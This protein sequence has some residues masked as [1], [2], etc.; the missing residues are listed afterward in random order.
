MA[1]CHEI[2]RG[3]CLHSSSALRSFLGLLS[4]LH[5]SGTWWNIFALR[6]PY[7][8]TTTT[9][10]TFEQTLPESRLI[11]PIFCI[12]TLLYFRGRA[13]CSN[14]GSHLSA[15]LLYCF[16]SHTQFFSD[17]RIPVKNSHLWRHRNSPHVFVE[18]Q[19]TTQTWRKTSQNGNKTEMP[20]QVSEM[21]A[22]KN[23]EGLVV[24]M[25][26]IILACISNP[27]SHNYFPQ[28]SCSQNGKR[29]RRHYRPLPVLVSCDHFWLDRHRRWC[30]R[31]CKLKA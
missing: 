16:H 11:G 25:R 26:R 5:N 21:Y 24:N 22:M 13:T 8:C 9:N 4:F 30:L 23:S 18:E 12:L 3:N 2:P 1:V 31:K 14:S 27:W 19:K 29:Y 15:V 6:A 20:H 7:R 17:V 10:A 28:S